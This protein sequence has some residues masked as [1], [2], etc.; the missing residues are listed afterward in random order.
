[1]LHGEAHTGNVLL[2]PEG[3]RWTDFEDVC[4]GAVEW[5]PGAA[6]RDRVGDC[7]DLRRLEVLAAV[8]TDDVQDPSLYD[9]LV[10]ALRRRV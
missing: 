10:A 2:A 9:G 8:L 3:P 4:V 5:D 6:D 7:R 1:M